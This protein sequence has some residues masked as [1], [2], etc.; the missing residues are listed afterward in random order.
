MESSELII[1][2]PNEQQTE[3]E[4]TEEQDKALLFRVLFHWLYNNQ[5]TA[6]AVLHNQRIDF[7]GEAGRR[8]PIPPY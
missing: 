7:A 5:H 2:I 8:T 3:K 1:Q 6:P 4:N